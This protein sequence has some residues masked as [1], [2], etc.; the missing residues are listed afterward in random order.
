MPE[1]RNEL[2]YVLTKELIA[3]NKRLCKLFAK[4]YTKPTE[5]KIENT[6][7]ERMDIIMAKAMFAGP[8]S[9]HIFPSGKEVEIFC[10]H[11]DIQVNENNRGALSTVESMRWF[12]NQHSNPDS[13]LFCLLRWIDAMSEIWTKADTKQCVKKFDTLAKIYDEEVKSSDE[14]LS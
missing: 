14:Q 7:K 4:E 5:S 13:A 3:K 12:Y 9:R 6:T 1:V 11:P 8:G 2:N 10:N